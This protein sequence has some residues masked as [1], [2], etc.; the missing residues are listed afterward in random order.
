MIMKISHVHVYDDDNGDGYDDRDL[1]VACWLRPAI[2]ADLFL[3]GGRARHKVPGTSP[4][5][6]WFWRPCRTLTGREIRTPFCTGADLSLKSPW[7]WK[8]W[9]FSVHLATKA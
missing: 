2:S 5:A 9:A 8:P 4:E 3:T 6:R 7:S 1:S